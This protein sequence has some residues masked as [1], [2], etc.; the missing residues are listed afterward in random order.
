MPLG[1]G[2]LLGAGLFFNPFA[3]FGAGGTFCGA[4]GG[5][6][7]LEV[8][9]R[10]REPSRLAVGMVAVTGARSRSLAFL[11]SEKELEYFVQGQHYIYVKG[12]C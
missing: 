4:G 1:A 6:F 7:A 5:D 3:F 2:L 12:K 8:D 9:R 10:D 11:F